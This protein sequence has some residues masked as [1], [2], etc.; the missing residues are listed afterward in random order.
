MGSNKDMERKVKKL[1]DGVERSEFVE[2]SIEFLEQQSD[3]TSPIDHILSISNPT[4][5]LDELYWYTMDLDDGDIDLTKKERNLVFIMRFSVQTGNEGILSFLE[6]FEEEISQTVNAFN[7][8]SM[9]NALIYLEKGMDYQKGKKKNGKTTY[10][11]D[12][13]HEYHSDQHKEILSNRLKNYIK[14]N[15]K[16]FS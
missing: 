2:E 1:F 5:F 10:V 12:I 3:T 13:D 4:E 7:D 8:A 6:H 9:V 14:N 16:E 11:I 15:R